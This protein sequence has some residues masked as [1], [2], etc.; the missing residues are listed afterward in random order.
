MEQQCSESMS[1]NN[2]NSM[3]I[4]NLEADFHDTV[5][6]EFPYVNATNTFAS[7][8]SHSSSEP[9][10]SICSNDEE[11]TVHVLSDHTPDSPS[12]LS[13]S[14]LRRRRPVSQRSSEDMCDSQFFRNNPDGLIDFDRHGSPLS[15][16][17]KHHRSWSA[18]NYEKS[19]STRPQ[20]SVGDGSPLHGMAEASSAITS[21]GSNGRSINYESIPVNSP[22]NS[23][24]ILLL[25]LSELILK[26][27]G[28]QTQLFS[29][30]LTL[31]IWLLQISYIFAS[32]PLSVVYQW[33]A[34]HKFSWNSI[35]Q[36]SYV[37]LRLAYCFFILVCVVTS[38]FLLSAIMMKWIVSE[39]EHMTEELIFDYT[40][41]TPMAFVPII[42]CSNS[43]SPGLIEKTNIGATESQVLHFD[44]EVQATVSLTLPESEYNRNL[45]VFQVRVDFLS[46]DGKPIAT[47]RQPSMFPFRSEPI[48]LLS[49]FFKL[50]PLLA[51]YSSESQTL[52]ITFQGYTEKNDVR[53]SCS[54]VVLEQRAEFARGGG[55]PEIYTATLKLEARHPYWKRVLW[56][57]KSVIYMGMTSMM[58]T[59]ELL[60]MLLC[61]PVVFSG[62]RLVADA[63]RNTPLS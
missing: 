31:P 30:Y 63:S 49:T 61:C 26:V 15:Q 57:W 33:I 29:T 5:E 56:Y 18:N 45:G 39:P 14:G 38:S 24:P 59:V 1:E 47:I 32:D 17:K 23:F 48:R 52:D 13:S 9:D 40:R 46:D 2:N 36:I 41:D 25:T 51:G 27:L 58:F 50:A 11:S 21:V 34:K 42:S 16:R 10:H 19:N 35:Y 44:R 7:N 54:R 4:G 62:R 55:I 12:S 3:I 53:T 8:Q 28:F 22:T 37:L 60:F 43:S 6:E 20:S